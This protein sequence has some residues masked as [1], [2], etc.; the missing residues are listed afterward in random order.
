M[1]KYE[2]WESSSNWNEEIS[3]YLIKYTSKTDFD[4]YGNFDTFWRKETP[5]YQTITSILA[6][7]CWEYRYVQ[8]FTGNEKDFLNL[9]KHKR[10]KKK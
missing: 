7:I 10:I 9:Y 3:V 4:L 1:K 8:D 5:N 6:L 2:I